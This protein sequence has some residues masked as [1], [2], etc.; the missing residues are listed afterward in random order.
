[1]EERSWR[2]EKP[3]SFYSRMRDGTPKADAA[4]EARRPSREGAAEVIQNWN[5]PNGSKARAT[6]GVESTRK[7]ETKKGP[8]HE[9]RAKLHG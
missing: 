7:R 5:R 1:M 3:C 9:D 6:V 2:K 8:H 4:C